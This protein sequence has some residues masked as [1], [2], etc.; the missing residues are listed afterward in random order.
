MITTHSNVFLDM[1]GVNVYHCQLEE[2]QTRCYHVRSRTQKSNVL[3]DLG[4]KASDLLQS[5]FV[6]WVEGPSDR[7]YLRHWI[8]AVDRDLVEGIQ[9]TIMFYGGR[10]LSHV[11]FENSTDVDEFIE[12]GRLNRNA[13]IVVDSDRSKEREPLNRTKLRVKKA[14]EENHQ[15]VW[16]T[17]GREIENYV[18]KPLMIAALRRVYPSREIRV[19]DGRYGEVFTSSKVDKVAI[20]KAVSEYEADL[21]VLDLDRSIR[22]LA[23]A[24]QQANMNP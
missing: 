12:L 5:N 1:P 2:G 14:F 17:E 3:S 20:A 6:V 22:R 24:I 11:T 16:V 18:P 19:R 23:K 13:C 8:S 9:Y 7:H 10:L 21:S 15:Q 4:Y